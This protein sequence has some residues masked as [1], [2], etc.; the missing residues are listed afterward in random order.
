MSKI[1]WISG[2]AAVA[3]RVTVQ[4]TAYDATT[5]Y[6][7]TV[8]GI[9]ISV[10]A[11][12]SVN[13]TATAL[14]AAWNGS[15]HPYCSAVTAT[16]LTDTVTLTADAAGVPFVVTSSVSGG[17]GT[18][19]SATTA[20][21]NAGPND[22]S[23]AANWST[24]VVPANGDYVYLTNGSDPILWGLAQS[25]VA[26][27]LLQIEQSFIGQVGLYS[28]SFLTGVGSADTTVPEYRATYLATAAAI[29]RIG[30]N[31]GAPQARGAALI[32]LDLGSAAADVTVFATGASGDGLPPALLRVNNSGAQVRILEGTVG[33]CWESEAQTG[34]ASSVEVIGTG[35]VFMG[36]G[37]TLA[38][39]TQTA[40]T[41]V[42]RN[43]PATTIIEPSGVLTLA[44]SG[45]ITLLENRGQLTMAG[46]YSV[47][48][49]RG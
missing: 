20:T 44:G 29:V 12:G 34:Q 9:V 25:G 40:G 11:G 27:A 45:T 41:G 32:K 28:S 48:T 36:G 5:T 31:F 33:L 16:A 14:A 35:Q 47:T 13:A 26:P 23:T 8:G 15:T 39:H 19:G 22:Y 18:I 46:I 7:L 17:T 2:A 24:G 49:L 43:A 30:E 3:Q 4:V 38:S 6:K 42:A 10:I 21:A 37:F 1:Y